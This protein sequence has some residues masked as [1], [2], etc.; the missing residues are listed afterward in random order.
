M[1]VILMAKERV[2]QLHGKDLELCGYLLCVEE[3]AVVGSYTKHEM[4]TECRGERRWEPDCAAVL[5]ELC[6]CVPHTW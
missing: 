6:V 1:K 4:G 3:T 5:H 2:F